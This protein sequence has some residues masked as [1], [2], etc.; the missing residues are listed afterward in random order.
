MVMEDL[1]QRILAKA[2]KIKRYEQQGTQYKQKILFK[3]DQ[4]RFYQQLNGTSKNDKIMLSLMQTNVRSFGVT[5]G[6]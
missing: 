5:S 4:K 2:A 1:K 6:V 3:Q